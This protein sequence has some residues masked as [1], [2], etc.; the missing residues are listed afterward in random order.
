MLKKISPLALLMSSA[1]W[2]A[3]APAPSAGSLGN[4][5]RQE[6][7]APVV[8]LSAAPLLL[9]EDEKGSVRSPG[10]SRTRITLN[11]VVFSGDTA[12]PGV[13]EA[14]LQQV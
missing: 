11:K 8:P 12:I 6:A 10:E 9:P 14:R 4:Q 7:P 13:T 5:L 3:P 1:V 2:A